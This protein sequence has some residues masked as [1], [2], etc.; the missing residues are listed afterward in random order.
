MGDFGSQDNDEISGDW[1]DAD[2]TT[3][4]TWDRQSEPL[5]EAF[6]TIDDYEE[7]Q[8]QWTVDER[9]RKSMAKVQP[10]IAPPK[11]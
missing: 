3:V 10:G 2:E 4:S 6:E 1:P 8:E 7:A 9:V 11:A 5:V